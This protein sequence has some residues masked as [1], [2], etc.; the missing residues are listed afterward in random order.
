MKVFVD[1]SV[2]VAS[3][4]EEHADQARAFAVLEQVQSGKVEG[5]NC[6]KKQIV[7]SLMV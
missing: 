1:T 6:S 4:V 5:I 7:Q 3:V 2:L